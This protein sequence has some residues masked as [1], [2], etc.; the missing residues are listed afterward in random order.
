VAA[1][2]A[3]MEELFRRQGA[4]ADQQKRSMEFTNDR[5]E[6]LVKILQ[7]VSKYATSLYV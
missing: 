1:D 2:Q 4:W 7:Q 3:H 5:F 6:H